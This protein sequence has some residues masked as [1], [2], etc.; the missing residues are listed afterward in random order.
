V[1]R[2][3][4][5]GARFCGPP[6]S[7]NGGYTCGLVAAHLEG[8]TEVTLRRP[9]P[10][11]RPL[12]VELRGDGSVHVVDRGDTIAVGMPVGSVGVDAPAA[13]TP[14]QAAAA[15]RR[16]RFFLHPEEHSFPTCFVCGPARAEG[17]G[18]RLFPGPVEGRELLATPWV[19]DA[20]LAADSD[21]ACVRPEF[22]WAALDCSG[23]L[24]TIER[25]DEERAGPFV[26]GRLAAVLLAPVPVGEPCIAT[27]W[28]LGGEG[29]KLHAGSAVLAADGTVHA[30][31]RSTWIGL[32]R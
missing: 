30:L 22:V 20:S 29:R 11:E 8:P 23:G 17:D 25:A 27:G 5:V 18:L 12:R 14:A 31:A 32:R 16:A 9:P 28:R 24:S 4:V 15:R 7:G 21:G 26:L 2:D 1:T 13:V 6:D 3:I 19:P 10:L